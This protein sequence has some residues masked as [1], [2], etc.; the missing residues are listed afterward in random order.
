MNKNTMYGIAGGI[1]VA[2]VISIIAVVALK[3]P[4]APT[5]DMRSVVNAAVQ[6]AIYYTISDAV[7]PAVVTD[8]N[9]S[10]YTVYFKNEGETGNL[11]FQRSDDGGKTFSDPVRVN[12]REG[13][14]DVAAQWSSPGLAV[15]KNGEVFVLWYNADYSEPEK[16]PWGEITMRFT[17]SLDGGKTFEPARNPAPNDPRGEQSYPYMVVSSDN[18]IHISYLNLDYS[19]EENAAGTHTVVRMVSSTDAGRTFGRSAIVDPAACQC[20]ATVA[21]AGPDGEVYAASRSVFVETAQDLT[22]DKRT[23]YHG[24][25]LDKVVIRDITVARSTDGGKAQSFT[26]PSRVGRDDWYMNGCPDAGPGMDFDSKGRLHMAWFTGSET[27]LRGQGFYYTSSDDRGQS[28][29]TPVPIH[30]LSKQWIPPTTQYLVVDS[31][32]NSWIF[33]VNSEGLKKSATYSEDYTFDGKGNVHL[34]IVD[35]DGN[36][37]RN[38]AFATGDITKHYPFASG[39]GASIVM[40]WMDGK[41]VKIA[42]FDTA[43]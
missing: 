39:N 20:C 29:R 3:A 35:R 24:T 25:Y 10:I 21:A 11:Y 19:L 31:N 12:D 32:D 23:D 6:G 36:V 5:I 8:D 18:S 2:V 9:G 17:R 30:L 13:A 40:S 26:E 1:A 38:G 16:F 41:D 7:T 33:F 15:G 34:A 28:F 4:A 42:V 37:L 14:I 27:A 43:I 22:D